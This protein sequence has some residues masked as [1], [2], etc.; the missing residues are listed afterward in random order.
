[1]ARIRTI[2]PDAF[3]SESLSALGRGTRWTFAGLW[4]YADDEGR[5]RDDVRL[6]KAAL[7][8]LDD[9]VTLEDVETDLW[10][11]AGIGAVCRYEG[12]DGRK[13][14]HMPKWHDHQRINRPTPSKV[15]ACPNEPSGTCHE[16]HPD[17]S[18]RT[19]GGLSD[20]S[21]QERKGREV[22]QGRGR[23]LLSDKSDDT[24]PDRFDEF[25]E[26]YSHKVGRAKA[27]K[28]YRAAL[29]KPGVT[30]DLLIASAAAYI[31][32]QMSEGK[33]PEFTKHP[34]TWLHG[35]H[36]RDERPARSPRPA[37][38]NAQG[39]L[40]LANDMAERDGNVS[41]FPRQIGGAS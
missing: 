39:W 37:E 17:D 22:E 41:L 3:I 23:D 10:L 38:S 29:K 19:H 16:P 7:Y 26:T 15:P 20:D 30:D 13:Y 5:A 11:L 1:M 9:T 14:L 36:W 2:K 27:E 40:R 32:W 33:H 4:T 25:W 24:E 21:R 34:T 6:I 35:E 8:P 31:T 18:V 28:A 12:G